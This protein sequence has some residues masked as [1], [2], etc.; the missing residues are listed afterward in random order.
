MMYK[1]FV[2]FDKGGKILNYW[3]MLDFKENKCLLDE[4]CLKEIYKLNYF[5]I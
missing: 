4:I 2:F 5:L 3:L 1:F